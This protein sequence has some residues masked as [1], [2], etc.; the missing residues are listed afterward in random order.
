M[1]KI[2]VVGAGKTGRGF[3]GRLLAEDGAEIIF[4][5]KNEELVKKLNEAGEFKISFFGDVREKFTVSSYKAYT[6][7]TAHI[8]DAD[9][10]LVSV[11]GKNLK[12]VGESLSKLLKD[13]K[14]YTIITCENSLNPATVLKEALGRNNVSVSESTVFCTTTDEGLDIQSENYPYLQCNA[15]LLDG[16][17]IS[18]KGIKPVEKFGN[19]LTRKL[20]TYNAASCVIAYLGWAKGY[21]DYAD[22]ANDPEILKMLD[23]N[24]EVTNRVLCKEF[25]YD[26][27]DQR[28][29]ALLSKT[30]FCS[31]AIKDTVAR[32]AREPQRKLAKGERIIGPMEL[33]KKHGENPE[34]LIKTAAAA[35][36]YEEAGETEWLEM[37]KNMSLE[38][39]LNTVCGLSENE[40]LFKAI[41]SETEKMR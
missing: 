8:E 2:V 17:V 16:A 3:I 34:I 22:A 40:E 5:D 18:V 39:I 32:N 41:L 11:G 12:D 7:E 25:G 19:F 9:L 21:E 27:D 13:D 30:K 1:K 38:K 36:L 4:I 6:W 35:L 15:D 37:K 20:Y 26:E 28:E 29:F 23:E 10:I 31:R 14:H 33:I 24:Y